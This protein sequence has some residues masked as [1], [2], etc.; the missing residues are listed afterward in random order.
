MPQAFK[1]SDTG[2]LRC[3]TSVRTS[4]AAAIRPGRRMGQILDAGR[5]CDLSHSQ[6]MAVAASAVTRRGPP[7][8][9]LNASNRK[10]AC[11]TADRFHSAATQK[12]GLVTQ[13]GI[14][15]VAEPVTHNGEADEKQDEQ[16][17]REQ[18]DPPFTR[19]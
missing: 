17:R 2:R 19:E 7:K 14:E 11:P 6:R 8:Q 10:A 3:S 9:A 15:L 18:Y 4:M 5:K 13:L 16:Q 12:L 1:A